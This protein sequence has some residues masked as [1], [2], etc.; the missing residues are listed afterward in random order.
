MGKIT[1][2]NNSPTYENE[3]SKSRSG[4]DPSVEKMGC[5]GVTTAQSSNTTQMQ[6]YPL[7]LLYLK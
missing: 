4:I 2:T 3:K 7:S 6:C 5:G 1:R